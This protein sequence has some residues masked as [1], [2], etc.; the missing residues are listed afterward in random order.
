MVPSP[1]MDVGNAGG[2]GS[3][4]RGL[5]PFVCACF[6]FNYLL[7]TGFLTIPWAFERAGLVLS[8]IG[9]ILVCFVANMASDY[10]LTAMA[11]AEALT[12]YMEC[13]GMT[14]GEKMDLEE[15]SFFAKEN[16]SAL[17]ETTALLRKI[18]SATAT[19]V[20]HDH[21][22]G[23]H[24]EIDTLNLTEHGSVMLE[25][26]PAWKKEVTN[27]LSNVRREESFDSN[28]FDHK[29]NRKLLVKDRK[30]EL[31]ELCQIFLGD[32]GFKAYGIAVV[33]DIYGFLWAYS[34]VF[35]SAMAHTFPIESEF[36]SYQLY[37][38]LFAVFVVPMSF[39]ELSEQAAVQIFLSGCRIVMVLLMICTPLVAM[40]YGSSAHTR[41]AHHHYGPPIS[42]F[43]SQTKPV[44]APSV[45]LSN[46][47]EMIPVIVFAVL[48]H[49]AVPGLADEMKQKSQVGNIFGY[50]LLLCAVAYSLIGI[51]VGWY[52]GDTNYESAN[53]NWGEYHAGTGQ[54]VIGDDGEHQWI[55]VVWWAQMISFFVVLFPAIDVIS[56]FPLYAFV[57][58]NSLMGLVYPDTIQ[59]VQHNR[60]VATGF[61][62]LAAIPPILGALF[63]R[64]LGIITDYS[65]LT[66]I[67]I[68]FCFPPLLYIYSEKKLKILDMPFHTSY[69][70]IGSSICSAKI[71]FGFG[72]IT[73]IFCFILLVIEEIN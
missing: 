33:L 2:N 10:I 72:V 65:G 52:F 67:A 68:A 26:V 51:V 16:N 63:V 35:G 17:D 55:H 12:V 73:I 34:S 24:E 56:A 38:L 18:D 44:G 32:A 54:L 57:L 64:N 11:R 60:R 39:L 71:M 3:H 28:D 37:V 8:T 15:L 66:G 48:F 1:D 30:F 59:Q 62:A 40:A 42:H 4:Q 29:C 27:A 6:T 61:R 47:H 36:D 9:M 45:D 31:T 21:D 58:G 53:L 25:K 14:G 20:D 7:G 5:S 41:H 22:Y 46:I 23:F 69:E 50:T 13:H 70:R 43:D 19:L 49:Q